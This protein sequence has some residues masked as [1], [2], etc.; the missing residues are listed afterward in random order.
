MKLYKQGLFLLIFASIVLSGCDGFNPFASI[1]HKMGK[2][3]TDTNKY[4]ERMA[5][6]ISEKPECQKF[7]D[8]FLKDGREAASMSATF[9]ALTIKTKDAANKAGCSKT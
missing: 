9:T 6:L 3:M 8:T 4:A 1:F 2:D 5:S 7:K